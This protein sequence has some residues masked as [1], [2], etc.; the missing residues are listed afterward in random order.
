[1]LPPLF[2]FLPFTGQPHIQLLQHAAPGK[3]QRT[4]LRKAGTFQS[5]FI[6]KRKKPFLMSANLLQE[7]PP[8]FSQQMFPCFYLHENREFVFICST[9]RNKKFGKGGRAGIIHFE[10]QVPVNFF[11]FQ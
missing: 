9:L 10:Y 3:G 11:D 1:M 5:K 7:S 8:P 6:A 2:I 4:F